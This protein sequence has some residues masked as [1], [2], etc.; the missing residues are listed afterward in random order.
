M[1]KKW[2]NSNC[3]GNHVKLK[4]A[5]TEDLLQLWMTDSTNCFHQCVIVCNHSNVAVKGLVHTRKT[6]MDYLFV[7]MKYYSHAHLTFDSIYTSLNDCLHE[8]AFN[9]I[10]LHGREYTIKWCNVTYKPICPSKYCWVLP[11]KSWDNIS[12][13]LS[14]VFSGYLD[15][16]R[17]SSIMCLS[18]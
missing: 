15:A 18:W 17:V 7:L 8:F 5:Q 12:I 9:K 3:W 14:Y 6:R 11:L 2:K 13:I 16:V 4:D 1:P 10:L